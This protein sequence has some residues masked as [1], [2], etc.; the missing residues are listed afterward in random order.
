MDQERAVILSDALHRGVC[1]ALCAGGHEHRFVLRKAYIDLALP[2]LPE[3][4]D[5]PVQKRPSSELGDVFAIYPHA[6]EREL[7]AKVKP[8]FVPIAAWLFGDGWPSGWVEP[9]PEAFGDV[10][11]PPTAHTGLSFGAVDFVY[12]RFDNEI[13][14]M[15][16][17]ILHHSKETYRASVVDFRKGFGFTGDFVLTQEI[18]LKLAAR[19]GEVAKKAAASF[20]TD[21]ALAVRRLR[22]EA[23]SRAELEAATLEWAELYA[24]RQAVTIAR[25]EV[26]T[27]QALA[28][29][30]A[31][32]AMGV[33][34]QGEWW[35]YGS[36]KCPIC[37]AINADCP[38]T[39][40]DAQGIGIPHPRCGDSWHFHA[41][42]S[43][44]P[45]QDWQGALTIE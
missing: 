29:M 31:A 44:K 5:S 6:E 32:E 34:E 22:T 42:P 39:Y 13:Q 9:M 38:Y 41:A 2:R 4:E 33:E 20:N 30:D 12:A 40:S 35:F 45:S 3:A 1:S 43:V 26:A 8:F 27:T 15:A 28:V 19:A 17:D 14:A 23:M 37:V 25:T 21:L 10:V 16:D 18:E 24:E 36:L 11:A 7:A